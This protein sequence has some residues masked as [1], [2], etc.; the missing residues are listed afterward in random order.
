MQNLTLIYVEVCYLM[1]NNQINLSLYDLTFAHN[2]KA[3]GSYFTIIKCYMVS[4]LCKES[5][6][7]D[8]QQFHQYQ[9]NELSPSH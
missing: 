5:I 1:E 9:Q 8:G 3:R 7:S 2:R 4:V 6:N